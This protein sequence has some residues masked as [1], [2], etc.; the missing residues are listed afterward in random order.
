MLYVEFIV[1]R[2]L[3]LLAFQDPGTKQHLGI[4]VEMYQNAGSA[5]RVGIGVE[6]YQNA[7]S[8]ARVLKVFVLS[9]FIEHIKC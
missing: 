5:A 2:N 3:K 1:T 4:G 7:G 9:E 8:A 6:M